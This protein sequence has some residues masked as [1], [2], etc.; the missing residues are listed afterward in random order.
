MAQSCPTLCDPMDHSLPGSSVHGIFQARVLEWVAISFSRVI[1][2][3]QG[4]NLGLLHLRQ[5]LYHLSHQGSPR[6]LKTFSNLVGLLWWSM[7]SNVLLIFLLNILKKFFAPSLISWII[8]KVTISYK[9]PHQSA[10]LGVWSGNRKSPSYL[11]GESLIQRI[12]S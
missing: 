8:F 5:T 1:F 7:C 2:P 4:S 9:R 10:S 11:E 12:I 3:T 6:K